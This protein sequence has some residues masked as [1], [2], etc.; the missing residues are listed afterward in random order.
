V[1]IKELLVTVLE[2]VVVAG[3]LQTRQEPQQVALDT[4]E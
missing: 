4:K 3:I 1:H 2:L